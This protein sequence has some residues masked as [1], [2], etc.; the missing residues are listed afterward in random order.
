LEVTGFSH[1]VM[2]PPP[3]GIISHEVILRLTAVVT[4]NLTFIISYC[5]LR[6]RALL[7][8]LLFVL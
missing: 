2:H 1:V 7:I 4:S 6:D 8:F 5:V 3:H